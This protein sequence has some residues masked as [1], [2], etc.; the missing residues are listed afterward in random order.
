M[1]EGHEGSTGDDLYSADEEDGEEEE[2]AGVD[3]EN[4]GP[5]ELGLGTGSRKV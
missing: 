1:V 4:R 3:P 5:R 2:N